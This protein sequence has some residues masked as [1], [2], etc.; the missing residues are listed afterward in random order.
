VLTTSALAAGAHRLTAV[1]NGTSGI[2][3]STSAVL[4]LTV[5]P[6]AARAATQTLLSASVGSA[7]YGQPVTITATVRSTQT[8]AL[9]PTGSVTFK[10]GSVIL[11]TVTLVGGS[12]TLKLSALRVGSHALTAVYNGDVRSAASTSVA[13]AL[14][15]NQ[16]RTTVQFA[17]SSLTVA[18]GAM[19]TLRATVRTLAPSAAVP[20]GKFTFRADNIELGTVTLDRSGTATLTIV[21]RLTV[22]QHWITAGYFGNESFAAD[23]SGDILTVR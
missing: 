17:L 12:A 9:T 5:A 18:A 11:G 21:N 1:Y 23:A 22:K 4:A 2:T 13:R 19:L 16:A 15:V 20:T 3:S 7:F 8:G 6:A 14:T 10:D